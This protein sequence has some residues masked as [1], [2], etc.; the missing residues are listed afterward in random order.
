MGFLCVKD[1]NYVK[2]SYNVYCKLRSLVNCINNRNYIIE[3][4]RNAGKILTTLDNLINDN[5][6]HLFNDLFI[7]YTFMEGIDLI[8]NEDNNLWEIILNIM[9]NVC[10]NDVYE[11]I[12]IIL[13]QLFFILIIILHG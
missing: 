10:S 13:L 9:E 5:N 8:N 12:F 1:Y 6:K 7:V 4:D 3:F 11:N 2:T